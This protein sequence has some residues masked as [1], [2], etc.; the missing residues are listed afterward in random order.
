MVF[1]KR[2]ETGEIDSRI[3]VAGRP[4]VERKVSRREK[5]DKELEGLMRKLRPHL[6]ASIGVI[7][8]VMKGEKTSDTNKLKAAALVIAEYR[9][10]TLDVWGN[11]EDSEGSGEVIEEQE[12]QDMAPV[13]SLKIVGD[14]S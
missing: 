2:S 13:F 9:K 1:K 14:D 6:A 5:K 8:D 10:L 4:K 12:D 3:N 11:D 7:S